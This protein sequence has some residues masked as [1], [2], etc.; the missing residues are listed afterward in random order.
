MIDQI[1]NALFGVIPYAFFEG[2][3]GLGILFEFL[4]TFFEQV[5]ML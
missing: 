2:I 1:F 4:F 3:V 5:D